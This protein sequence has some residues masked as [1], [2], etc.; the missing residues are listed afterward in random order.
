MTWLWVLVREKVRWM[1]RATGTDR[2]EADIDKMAS[3]LYKS[4]F[5]AEK[6]RRRCEK[7]ISYLPPEKGYRAADM[8][9]R[10]GYPVQHPSH[11][12]DYFA[13]SA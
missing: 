13:R 6:I 10:S 12:K 1:F 2:L 3:E 8:M 4:H 9:A 11:W 7:L 5:N